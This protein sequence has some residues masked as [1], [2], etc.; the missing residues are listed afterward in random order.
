MWCGARCRRLS[1]RERGGAYVELNIEGVAGSL[2]LH[3]QEG[4][5][6][7]QA[8]WPQR[9]HSLSRALAAAR[10]RRQLLP[11]DPAVQLEVALLL[12]FDRRHDEAC[13]ELGGVLQAAAAVADVQRHSG[14][15]ALFDPDEVRRMQRLLDR[16]QLQRAFAAS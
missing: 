9:G 16:V 14:V 13:E 3:S 5:R 8:W 4:A 7:G 10:K 12:Y 11:D 2:G 6:G 15:A 1:C